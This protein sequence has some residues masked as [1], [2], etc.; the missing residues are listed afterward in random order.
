MLASGIILPHSF[1]MLGTFLPLGI[2]FYL[3]QKRKYLLARLLFILI[4]MIITVFW[5]IARSSQLG[6]LHYFYIIFPIPIV[7]LFRSLKIQ[8]S[9]VTLAFGCF[10][11][12]YYIINSYPAASDGY[13]SPYFAIF[14]VA[15]WLSMSFIMLLFFV[16]EVDQAESRLEE[17]NNDL[18]EF[19]KIASHDL[20]EPLRT[21]SSYTSLIR[22]KHEEELSPNVSTYLGYIETRVKR[23]DNLLADLS[24]YSAIDFSEEELQDIDLNTVLNNVKDDLKLKIKESGAVI[25]N[26]HLPTLR[27]REGHI[28]QLF[29]NLIQNSIKFQAPG[30]N[31]LP[32]IIIKSKQENNFHFI[33]FED[34][35]IGIKEEHLE[36]IFVKFKR[37]H[38]RDTYDGTGLGLATCK[39]IIEKYNG[40]IYI[41]SKIGIGTTITLKFIQN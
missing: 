20:K 7:I 41:K 35:G 23:L 33:T 6:N 28:Y 4:P 37:L 38:S 8:V 15:L 1:Y 9:L 19:S 17:T 36:K 3:N 21:I 11:A 34:N 40:K 27:A 18:E 30:E 10:L 26:N 13:A 29:Q 2:V 14:L 16:S 24:N 39:R 25:S 32:K 12:S 22:T 31:N 5:M